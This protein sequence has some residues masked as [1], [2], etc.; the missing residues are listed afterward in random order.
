[1]R[2]NITINIAEIASFWLIEEKIWPILLINGIVKAVSPA[3]AVM[4]CM[5]GINIPK[6]IPSKSDAAVIEK[7]TSTLS[8]G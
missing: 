4:L 3:F 5:R 7:S 6:L 2:E 8:K 1:M